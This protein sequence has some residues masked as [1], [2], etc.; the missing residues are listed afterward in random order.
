MREFLAKSCPAFS[1][2][3]APTWWLPK[4]ANFVNSSLPTRVVDVHAF[5]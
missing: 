5:L 3:Y 4:Y 1:Q 2:T